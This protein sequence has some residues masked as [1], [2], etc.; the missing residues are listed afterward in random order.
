MPG[1]CLV[2]E[3]KNATQAIVDADAI[4]IIPNPSTDQIKIDFDE[5]DSKV[6][7]LQIYNMHG[8]ILFDQFLR[9]SSQLKIN[10]QPFNSGIYY[11][12]I[13]LSNN[14]LLHKTFVKI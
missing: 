7:K 2:S 11:L 8:Q 4:Q 12:K 13:Q 3:N 14:Q 1:I 6:E 10:L 5:L 9:A